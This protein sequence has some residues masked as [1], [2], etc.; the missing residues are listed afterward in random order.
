MKKSALGRGLD[1]LLPDDIT[2]EGSDI[3]MLPITEIDRNPDQP[4]KEFN[5]EALQQ[6]ADS[7]REA[8]LLQPIL[9]TEKKGR[10]LIVA[11]ERRFRA[12]RLAELDTIPCLV[13]DLSEQEQMEI[14][15][16]EN[17]QREDLNPMEEALAIRSLMK[18]CNY[19]QEKAAKRLGKSRPAVANALRLLNLPEEVQSAVAAKQ[20]SAGHARVLAGLEDEKLQLT[21]CR[22]VIQEGLSVRALEKLAAAPALTPPSEKPVRQLPLELQDMENRLREAIGVR[23]MLKGNRKKGKVI[24]Q[25]TNEDELEF[26]YQA[27]EKLE[28]R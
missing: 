22:R 1:V 16:I 26:I 8:G 5:E 9:V 19:T 3:R 18:K 17:L 25:Y 21:L 2:F 28:N 6:L 4:R 12:A 24:L 20:L 11:G 10:Y 23:A 27:M 13:R 14:A 7:I 15:L